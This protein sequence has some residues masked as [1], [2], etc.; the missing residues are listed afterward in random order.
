M[1]LFLR[2]E[3]NLIACLY[4]WER[5]GRDGKIP[6][7]GK[8]MG[9]L[10]SKATELEKMGS[11][12]HVEGLAS[13]RRMLTSFLVASGGVTVSGRASQ[14]VG[15]SGDGSLWKALFLCLNF[16]SEVGGKALLWG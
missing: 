7:S 12:L 5:F 8:K 13:E 6:H 4:R 14:R 15:G 3:S 16:L 9:E 11:H 10:Q 2:R 1:F